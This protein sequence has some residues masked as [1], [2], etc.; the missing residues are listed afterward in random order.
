MAE[1]NI[2]ARIAYRGKV[3]MLRDNYDQFSPDYVVVDF[4]EGQEPNNFFGVD[5]PDFKSKIYNDPTYFIYYDQGEQV[6]F[7]KIKKD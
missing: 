6:I 4:R 1:T 2:A 7:K 5:F 3:I